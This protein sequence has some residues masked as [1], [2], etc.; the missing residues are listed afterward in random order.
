MQDGCIFGSHGS[1]SFDFVL[2]RK[3]VLKYLNK[4]VDEYLNYYTND[5]P[6]DTKAL[7]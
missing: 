6:S 4:H 7:A 2:A 5:H 1:V 3:R